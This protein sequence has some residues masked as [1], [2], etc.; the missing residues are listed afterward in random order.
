MKD[1]RVYYLENRRKYVEIKYN[2]LALV[3]TAKQKKN[4]SQ[5][6]GGCWN[7]QEI[8]LDSDVIDTVFVFRT[9]VQCSK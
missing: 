6:D 2:A 4:T 3:S 8:T 9:Y 5:F 1:R 7:K